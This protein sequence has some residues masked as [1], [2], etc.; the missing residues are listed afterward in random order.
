MLKMIKISA[1]AATAVL[2]VTGCS[3]KENLKAVSETQF[4]YTTHHCPVHMG[5]TACPMP[6]VKAIEVVDGDD[7]NDGVLNSA[8]KCP[9]TVPYQKVDANGCAVVDGDDDNDGVLNSADKCPGTVPYQKVDANGCAVVD[10]DDDND[11]VLNSADK[12]PATAAGAKVDAT[13]CTV[14]VDGDDDKDG[15]LNSADKCPSTNSNVTKVDADG[16]ASEVKLNINFEFNSSDV[17]NDSLADILSFG[18]FMNEHKAYKAR[19]EGHTDATGPAEYNQMLSQKRAQA[20]TDL[21]VSEAKV[22]ATRLT[23]VGKGESAPVAD[24]ATKAGR[25]EN[26]RTEAHI[27]K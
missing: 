21:I 2:V 12:C 23:A 9:G 16:C 15:V 25:T 17:T 3:T 26:R 22:D 27:T 4:F 20:V 18:Y 19:I 6:E 10:G 14:V 8:D 24:N 11:G 7:D 5:T 1:I 13:G